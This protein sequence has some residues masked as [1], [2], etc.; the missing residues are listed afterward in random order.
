MSKD[1][2]LHMYGGLHIQ[3]IQNLVFLYYTKFETSSQVL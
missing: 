1:A 2:Q 3:L